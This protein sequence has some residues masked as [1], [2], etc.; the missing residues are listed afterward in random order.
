VQ[1][2]L[3]TIKFIKNHIPKL[4]NIM[5]SITM[6]TKKDQPFIWKKEQHEAFDK[7]KAAVANAILC[8][9]GHP[10]NPTSST[11]MLHRN[12]PWEQGLL[13]KSMAPNR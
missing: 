10:T 5:A 3:R 11:Q 13:R 9:Y 4:A 1:G 2:F 12:M 6:P 8:N 7:T